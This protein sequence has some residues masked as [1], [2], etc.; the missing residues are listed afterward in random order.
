M[1]RLALI[2]LMAIG[3]AIGGT[4]VSAAP[5]STSLAGIGKAQSG[6]ELVR[7]KRGH[8]KRNRH[9]RHNNWH[10]RSHWRHNRYRGWHRY[11]RRPWNWRSRGCVI[12][13]PVW[14]CP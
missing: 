12:I 4:A 13:G 9:Y 14:M 3:T 2:C 5:A 8:W 10:H 7:H 1:K 6:V 11:H